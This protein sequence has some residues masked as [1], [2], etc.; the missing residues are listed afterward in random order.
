VELLMVQKRQKWSYDPVGIVG[1]NRA[2]D[3]TWYL[4][5]L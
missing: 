5:K 2:W 4:R 3:V 1:H